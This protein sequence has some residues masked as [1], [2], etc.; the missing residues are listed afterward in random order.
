MA[1]TVH[2]R[3]WLKIRDGWAFHV[4]LS[5]D[6]GGSWSYCG[7]VKTILG[8]GTCPNNVWCNWEYDASTILDTD[9]KINNARLRLGHH[10]ANG[11]GMWID[12]AYLKIDKTLPTEQNIYVNTYYNTT[13]CPALQGNGGTWRTFGATPYLRLLDYPTNYILNATGGMPA[14]AEWDFDSFTPII[15]QPSQAG[16]WSGCCGVIELE[17]ILNWHEEEEVPIPIKRIVRKESPTVQAEYFV[18][19]PRRIELELKSSKSEKVALESCK[20]CHGWLELYDYDRSFVDA[21]FIERL[22]YR[23]ARDEDHVYP[24]R[25][26]MTLLCSST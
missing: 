2:L 8:G 10:I 23:W 15:V 11:D 25:G 13:S 21:V 4:W 17:H 3:I 1:T 5:G 26:R 19:L 6:N 12:Y 22:N 9:T 24:W 16:L 18:R 7:V 20:H 14:C